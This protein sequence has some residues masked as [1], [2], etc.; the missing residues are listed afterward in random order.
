MFLVWMNSNYQQKMAIFRCSHLVRINLPSAKVFFL[1]KF[2]A[3]DD[4]II[5]SCMDIEFFFRATCPGSVCSPSGL[6]CSPHGQL[7]PSG[8]AS[9]SYKLPTGVFCSCPPLLSPSKVPL[10]SSCNVPSLRLQ[11]TIFRGR[12]TR[13]SARTQLY[14]SNSLLW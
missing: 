9:M 2:S 5:C 1:H 11:C 3:R 7:P 4:T 8:D 14:C 10:T 13:G 12:A 6:R